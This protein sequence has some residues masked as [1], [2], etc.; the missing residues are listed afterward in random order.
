MKITT[1]KISE[2]EA[3]EL[4]SDLIDPDIT[5][6]EKSKSKGKDRRHNILNVLKNFKSVFTG[7]SLN[8]SNKPS[9]SE[10]SI[11]ER[12]KLRRQRFD[13]I[14]EKENMIDP[15]L[16]RKYF[17]YPSPSDMFKNLNKTMGSEENKAQVNEIKDRLAKLM[18][19]IECSPTSDAK[20]IGNRNNMQE[21]VECILSLIN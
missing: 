19:A 20:E 9:E 10:D 13:G 21:I 12:T 5:E 7:I 15:E 14:A 6:L 1:Q 16:F 17:E 11:A 3:H 18:E 8:S 2:N 4:Y